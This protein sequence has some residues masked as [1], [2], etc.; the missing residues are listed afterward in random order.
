MSN[1]TKSLEEDEI[2]KIKET[3]IFDDMDTLI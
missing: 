3:L 2:F 1:E